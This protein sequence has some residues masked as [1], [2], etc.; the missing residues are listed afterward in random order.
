MYS[1]FSSDVPSRKPSLP[2]D[3]N[4]SP[5][6][7]SVLGL[8]LMALSYGLIPYLHLSLVC[9]HTMVR[10]QR[11]LHITGTQKSFVESTVTTEHGQNVGYIG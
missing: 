6:L 9:E 8:R 11:P 5:I 4:D 7:S 3:L 2:R 10:H 1:A